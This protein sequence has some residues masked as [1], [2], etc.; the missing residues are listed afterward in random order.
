MNNHD[1]N[2][3][4]YTDGIDRADGR[5]KVTGKAK[6]SAEYNQP[7]ITYAVLVGSRI[8]YGT[9]KSIDTRAAKSA[10]GVLEVIT[11]L[12]APKIPG[13][14][15][16]K[17]PAKPQ[18]AGGPL[19][20]FN[21]EK[22][23]FNGMPIA[24]VIADT[25]ERAT[26][27]GSLIKAEYNEEAH[28]TDVAKNLDKAVTPSGPR[29]ED[30]KKG[31]ENAWKTAEAS[32]SEEYII[33]INVHN[34]M[35]LHAIIAQWDGPDRV[36][37]WDKTQGV[38]STQGTIAQ[39]FK[40]PAENVHV[41]SQFVGGAFGSALRT[42]PHEIAAVMAAQVVKKP[43]KL[44]LTREQMFNSVGYRPYTWQKISMGATKDGKLVGLV[45]EAVGQSSA[46]E[47]FT[48]GTVNL[49]RNM[50]ACPNI[51]TIYKIS[52][53]DVGTPTWMRGP[54]ET[55]GA[56]ALE[57]A[58]DEMAAKLNLD[59]IEFRLRNY[60]ET[61]PETGK[62][63]SGKNLK[64]AYQLGAD[65]IGWSNRKLE[66]G[67]L[68]EDGWL[69][70]YG[71]GTGIFGAGR[72]RATIKATLTADGM[73]NLQTAVSDIGPGTGTMMVKI[74][75]DT[76]DIPVN[77]IRFEIGDSA[78]PPSPTQGGSM[79]TSTVGSAV[80]EACANL[81][82]QFQK[83]AGNGGTDNP[84]YVKILKDHNLPQLSVTYSGQ[85]NEAG[86]AF[87]LHSFSVHFIKV[88]VNPRTGVVRVAAVASVADS[89]RVISPKTARSQVVGG[90]IGGIG[91]A[92]TEEGIFDHRFGKYVNADL[93][94]Y[95]VPVNA[96]IPQIDALFVNKPD[97]NVNPI[98][99]KGMGEIAL[100][101]MAAAV[102]NAVYNA[103]G[104][105]IR[106]LPITPDKLLS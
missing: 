85:G 87:S 71:M 91:M 86:K 75:S 70:G 96:D 44:M 13:Y 39:A 34:P 68:K 20:L 1:I 38:K 105:R 7:G 54:G 42:W 67:T 49:S 97:F 101:G 17:D 12:N 25:F 80:Q 8:T 46:Y 14:Q 72:G 23:W 40:I 27:A 31:D 5:L 58:M 33:P 84:D 90:A 30:Y 94:N 102:A 74:A 36:T 73:L 9:I 47:T 3:A 11:Y 79:I 6:Y 78:L 35:E 103:T 61:D 37:V 57:C 93:A 15:T 48:E 18:T 45:H 2:F 32:L 29:F 89:G 104:K 10:P 52:H 55:S 106:Q 4:P 77:R 16:G 99:A 51:A 66:P 19:K 62:P 98:G 24:M 69:V 83:L 28:E 76:L 82:E 81:K 26:Y 63:F 56:Y 22:V 50:Y 53:V 64:D 100:I 59:P 65:K 88:K 95:H 60:A 41:N 92:L 21:D 43:V